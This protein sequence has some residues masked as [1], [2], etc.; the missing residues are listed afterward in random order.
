MLWQSIHPHEKNVMAINKSLYL[1]LGINGLH[2]ISEELIIVL[3]KIMTA[4]KTSPKQKY[5]DDQ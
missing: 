1:K 3:I 5:Y 2:C 4:I